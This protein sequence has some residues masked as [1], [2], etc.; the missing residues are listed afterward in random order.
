MCCRLEAA[1]EER[2]TY[3]HGVLGLKV[4]VEREAHVGGAV[5]KLS[6]EST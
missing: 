1:I 5:S 4:E 6:E 3:L 2:G